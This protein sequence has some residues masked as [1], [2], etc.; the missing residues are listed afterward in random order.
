MLAIADVEHK[1]YKDF[2]LVAACIY[3]LVMITQGIYSQNEI[4]SEFSQKS[5][6]LQAESN[7]INLIFDDFVKFFL[8]ISLEEM[9]PYIQYCSRLFRSFP[10]D[11][12]STQNF[13]KVKYSKSKDQ[14]KISSLKRA[15]SSETQ[16]D[17]NEFQHIIQNLRE[18]PFTTSGTI[19]D[20]EAL[21]KKSQFIN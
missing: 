4:A 5:S 16:K 13:G 11:L 21:G 15:S 9:L 18:I 20:I 10:T 2:I 19:F 3:L 12:I 6:Y 14:E 1:S 8:E 17:D 7:P